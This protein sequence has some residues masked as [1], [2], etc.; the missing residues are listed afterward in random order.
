M[1]FKV[2]DQVLAPASKLIAQE[3]D[4]W[5]EDNPGV[6]VASGTVFCKVLRHAGGKKRSYIVDIV[7]VRSDREVEVATCKLKPVTNAAHL[8]IPSDNEREEGEPGEHSAA[9]TDSD[10]AEEPADAAEVHVDPTLAAEALQTMT[11][12]KWQA[13][14]SIHTDPIHEQFPNFDG[15]FAPRIRLGEQADSDKCMPFLLAFLPLQDLRRKFSTWDAKLKEIKAGAPPMTDGQLFGVL[16]LLIYMSLVSLG[17]RC[18]YWSSDYSITRS[19]APIFTEVMSW[20]AFEK[21]IGVMKDNLP[22]YE[23]G[24][25]LSDGRT[26]N[27]K[28]RLRHVRKW[29]DIVFA[30]AREKFTPGADIVLDETMLAWTA[31]SGPHLTHM[32]RKPT[33]LGVCARSLACGQTS[34]LLQWEWMEQQSEQVCILLCLVPV[35]GVENRCVHMWAACI[36]AEHVWRSITTMQPLQQLAHAGEEEME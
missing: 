24:E 30:R 6:S 13:A 34:V 20:P 2:G 15:S 10:S 11:E 31:D 26:V 7:G 17:S 25:V 18:E 36:A 28:D 14:E 35:E 29:Y 32:P 16:G 21:L 27:D 33:P 8:A 23:P 19:L 22:Q 1:P 12:D 3:L 4:D 9:E 5:K